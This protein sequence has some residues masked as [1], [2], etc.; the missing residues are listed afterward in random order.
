MVLYGALSI[1]SPHQLMAPSYYQPPIEQADTVADSGQTAAPVAAAAQQQP[2]VDSAD[3]QQQK[4][5][6][7]DAARRKRIKQAQDQRRRLLAQQ[8]QDELASTALGYSQEPTFG[9]GVQPFPP[10]F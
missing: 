1:V 2:I 9:F 5:A 3:A 6:R 4:L 8:R 7:Q 10:R